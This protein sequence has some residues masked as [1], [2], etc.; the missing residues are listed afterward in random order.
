[1]MTRFRIAL[2]CAA[3]LAAPSTS[4]SAQ[5]TEKPAKA[6]KEK[7]EKKTGTDSAATPPL[8]TSEAPIAVTLTANLGKLRGDKSETSPYHAATMSY[9]GADGKTVT[10]AFRVKTH[11]IW[12]L[13]HCVFP[14]L[15]LNFSNKDTKKTLFYDLQKPKMVS[16]CKDNDG[17]E[18]LL[19]KEMQLYRV[20]Q[21]ITPVSHRVRTLKVSYAD[22]ASGKVEMT[23]YAFV[24]E[25]PD[26]LSDRLGGKLTKAKGA[27]SDDFDPDALATAYMFEYL[28]GNLDYSFNGVHNAE[29]IMKNDGNG[30]LPVAYDFDFSG[31]VN[32]PYATVD[33]QFRTKRVID[34]LFRGYCAILPSY[35]AAISLIQSRKNKIYALYR[36][37]IGSLLSPETVKETLEYYDQFY[38]DVKTPRDAEANVLRT[39][40]RPR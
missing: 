31:A 3:V 28:I 2:L 32:A 33:P 1:M 13:K 10:V 7:K 27:Q 34:R 19:L 4:A 39:C 35:P 21:A 23:R 29:V 36:D 26:E 25:D 11:G 37:G 20:Y 9:T 5:K 22:S 8:F 15:R 18:Q 16:V 24:F 40:V 14:P 38:D 6:E 12:R 30:A 17:H